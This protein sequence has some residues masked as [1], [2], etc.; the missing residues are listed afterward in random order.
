M[1]PPLLGD[2]AVIMQR[3]DMQWQFLH[4]VFLGRNRLRLG[5]ADF[6]LVESWVEAEGEGFVWH[7]LDA[8]GPAPGP[9]VR[10]ARGRW[11]F[12]ADRWS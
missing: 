4:Q 2:V 11:W 6:E 8:V 1:D 3:D 7:D 9:T 5:I 12:R 10:L